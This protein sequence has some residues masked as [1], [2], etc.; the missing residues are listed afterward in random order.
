[1]LESRFANHAVSISETETSLQ[2]KIGMG[3]TVVRATGSLFHVLDFTEQLCWLASACRISSD[4]AW[5][6]CTPTISEESD[7]ELKTIAVDVINTGFSASLPTES[8]RC[9]MPI[10]GAAHIVDG[11]PI[12]RRLNNE[13]G[14]ELTLDA[15]IAFAGDVRANTFDS[16]LVIKSFSTLFVAMKQTQS[17]TVW[18]GIA[19]EE[20]ERISFRDTER[21]FPQPGLNAACLKSDRH[22]LGWSI[23]TT[24]E[25]GMCR[26]ATL[27]LRDCFRI[28]AS[29]GTRGACYSGIGRPKAEPRGGIKFALSNLTLSGGMF[30][31]AGASVALS[32]R[33]AA[34]VAHRDASLEEKVH[35]LTKVN[36][37]LY[38]DST[39]RGWLLDG[40]SA[41]LHLLRLRLAA[42]PYNTS[43]HFDI[44]NF[45]YADAPGG[46]KMSE[47]ALI[48]N[49]DHTLYE[50]R[51]DYVEVSK[52][53][54]ENKATITYWKSEQVIIDLWNLFEQMIDHQV[55]VRAANGV[56]LH[57]TYRDHLEG[58]PLQDLVEKKL[59]FEAAAVKL[60]G[61]GRGWVDFI[62][63][64]RAIT[65]LGRGFGDV[66]RP[67]DNTPLRCP[68]WKQ[69]PP[70]KDYLTVRL[71]FL[72]QI[73]TVYDDPS[74]RAVKLSRH[75]YWH[76]AHSLF[77]ECNCADADVKE[78]CDRIQVLLPQATVGAKTH[79]GAEVLNSAKYDQA[80][81]IFGR[82]RYWR[83]RYRS[84]GKPKFQDG[85]S[86]SESDS[87]ISMGSGSSSGTKSSQCRTSSFW[88][89]KLPIPVFGK[90]G[91]K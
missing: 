50:T 7:S 55:K 18:H 68:R 72:R 3:R 60:H 33:Q 84:K 19:K 62:H 32:H 61:S 77:E 73:C 40:A 67:A 57:G 38:D 66:I 63:D 58:W 4:G 25:V 15:M 91:S 36:V 27:V 29:K 26:H 47:E 80:A 54:R 78:L 71:Q 24:Q 86:D 1:M 88:R 10:I 31:N 51:K 9:W 64:I 44:T 34:I 17:S 81:V 20:R 16:K 75:A 46:P 70:D 28:D 52:D 65:L 14:L 74:R 35:Q 11:F 22:F 76:K 37:L 30:V 53:G 89:L 12:R 85:S 56:E 69:V 82:S 79:P 6:R 59:H 90:R 83:W 39:R 21:L 23:N 13:L 45:V 5:S 8:D 43:K 87:G 42:P 49:R 48:N 2:I 41:A